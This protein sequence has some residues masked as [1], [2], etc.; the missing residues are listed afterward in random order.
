MRKGFTLIE[1]LIVVTIIAI[2]A[3]AAIPY[4][5]EYIED[6]RI[7]RCKADLNEI[8]NGIIRYELDKG[9]SWAQADT[10]I[11]KLV[12]PYL[13]KALIDPWGTPYVIDSDNSVVYSGGFDRLTPISGA[14]SEDN[15]AVD[16]RPPLAMTKAY[17]IDADK[18]GTVND[19]DQ[20][21]CKFTRPLDNS[22]APDEADFQVFVGAGPAALFTAAAY[23][24]DTDTRGGILTITTVGAGNAFTPGRDT[25][26]ILAAS[27]EVHDLCDPPYSAAAGGNICKANLVTI[28]SL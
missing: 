6:A 14:G 23:A 13:A 22:L 7:S 8:K 25:L 9:V 27:T 17:W 24:F 16:F 10:N 2:L 5:Q 4:V 3:G 21:R 1:L 11:S 18:S 20:I 26:N 12:G 15:I 28:Q 19:G